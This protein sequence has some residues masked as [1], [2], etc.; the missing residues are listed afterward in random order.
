MAVSQ[1]D[2]NQNIVSRD[3]T[4]E[5]SNVKSFIAKAELPE[6]TEIATNIRKKVENAVKAFSECQEIVNSKK[7]TLKYSS[8]RLYM[9]GFEDAA[10]RIYFD[11]SLIE[12]DKGKRIKQCRKIALPAKTSDN[13]KEKTLYKLYFDDDFNI[14]VYKDPNGMVYF[15]SSGLIES[16]F[17]DTADGKR[18]SI[19]WS[20]N[21]NII[22]RGSY[23]KNKKDPLLL[24]AEERAKKM[25]KEFRESAQKEY[26]EYERR[27]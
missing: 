11:F 27:N 3:I 20:E 15:D 10:N 17:Y 4:P 1:E 13:E 19:R 6:D 12:T 8:G 2:F 23:D 5:L 16:V 18:Y 26:E 24:E 22:R 25:M 9:A 7:L 14:E 21:G